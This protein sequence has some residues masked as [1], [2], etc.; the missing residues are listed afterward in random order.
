[1]KKQ[2][3]GKGEDQSKNQGSGTRGHETQAKSQGS[4]GGS[5][6]SGKQDGKKKYSKVVKGR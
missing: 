2:T 6:N 4:K 3:E 5:G 1:M